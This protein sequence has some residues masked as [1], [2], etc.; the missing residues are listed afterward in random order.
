MVRKNSRKRANARTPRAIRC[1]YVDTRDGQLHY[2][3]AA[4]TA[5]A[6]VFLHQ[7]ASSSSSFQRVMQRLRLPNRLVALDTPGFGSSFAPRGW[8]KMADYARWTIEA[9]D[10][11][12]VKRFHV[13]GQH[14]G[15]NLAGELALRHPARVEVIR[16]TPAFQDA[17]QHD[18]ETPTATP[19]PARQGV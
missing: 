14:T 16:V 5:P 11:L 8:P 7:T 13:F 2:R 4:G 9:L 10:A 12:G 6:I 1:G 18:R 19:Q 15:A 3:E 17:A